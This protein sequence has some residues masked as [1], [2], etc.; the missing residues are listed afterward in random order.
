VTDHVVVWTQPA[1]PEWMDEATYAQM[2]DALEVRELR[3]SVR[4]PGFRVSELVLVTTMLDGAAY[5]KEELAEL[6]LERW[7]IEVCQADCTPRY[8]LCPPIRPPHSGRGG[9]A[10]PG[11]LPPGAHAGHPRATAM[12]PDSERPAPPRPRAA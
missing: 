8:S 11:P 12:R 1:R 2:P 10:E 6:F 4:Q 7:N 3:V 9:A 5:T